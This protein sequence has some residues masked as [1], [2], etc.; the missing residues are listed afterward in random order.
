M[1]TLG[2]P[3]VGVA[4][5]LENL[6]PPI[7]S[8]VVLPLAG[9]ASGMGHMNVVAAILW[10]M[11]GSVAGALILYWLG[12]KVGAD[13][14]RAI[15]ERMWLVDAADVDAALGFFHKHGTASVFFGRFVPGVRSLI[16]IP[17][18]V[19]RMPLAQFC[20]WTGA[21][22]L[23]WNVVL[24]WLGYALGESHHMVAE[25]IDKYSTVVYI[26]L[27]LGAVALIAYLVRRRRRR[28]HRAGSAGTTR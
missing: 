8:E 11:A 27:G 17:A 4:V 7:P 1:D 22:S 3:G 16:S 18:G 10:S 28:N 21:G 9:F 25:F 15:A 24:I 14:L 23:L 2:A 6:F 20:A 26:A 13:R 5:L 19:N 12:T